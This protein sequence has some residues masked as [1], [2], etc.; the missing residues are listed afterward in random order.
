MP[1]I[2]NQLGLPA[3]LVV[4]AIFIVWFVAGNELM[5]R[6]GRGL[7]IWSKRVLDPLGGRQAIQWITL[8][9]FRLELEGLKPPFTSGTMTGLVESWDVPI[10]WLLN[11]LNG[12]RDMVLVQLALRQQ[13][14]RGIEVFRPRSLLAG[15]ARQLAAEEGWATEPFEE[16]QLAAMPGATPQRLASELLA[17]LGARRA[18]LLRLALRRR[19][20]HLT[21]ALNIP[22]RQKVQPAELT[23]VLEGLA[24]V[25][26]RYATPAEATD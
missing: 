3:V 10:T 1:A 7:A 4:G 20:L 6:R 13:P 14:I 9:S 25:A 22:D 11:R 12:R 21:L 15:D 24:A 19:G 17:A 23:R 16:F 18:D 5:R 8:H 2:L 26:L